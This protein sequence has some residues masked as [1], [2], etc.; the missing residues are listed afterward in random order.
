MIA[1]SPVLRPGGHVTYI[2]DNGTWI[3]GI[4][5]ETHECHPKGDDDWFD[6]DETISKAT[7]A[8]YNQ[9]EGVRSWSHV[10]PFDPERH[11]GTLDSPATETETF[12]LGWH[13]AGQVLTDDD[14]VLYECT[15]CNLGPTVLYQR[16]SRVQY[17]SAGTSC[18]ADCHQCGAVRV[19]EPVEDSEQETSVGTGGLGDA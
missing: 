18:H 17:V 11:D 1:S 3:R 15:R 7:I 9:H 6:T 19:F 13:D 12:V 4:V 16:A 2:T 8:A 5:L 10:E 14:T